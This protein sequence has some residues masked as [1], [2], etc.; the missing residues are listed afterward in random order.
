MLRVT[1]YTASHSITISYS[2]C[3]TCYYVVNMV[4]NPMYKVGIFLLLIQFWDVPKVS[5]TYCPLMRLIIVL[6][7]HH[8]SWWSMGPWL[9]WRANDL[10]YTV[11]ILLPIYGSISVLYFERISQFKFVLLLQ[12]TEY[13]YGKSSLE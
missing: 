13:I 12:V 9:S 1:H 4:M 5:M 10:Q 6:K 3:F 2:E 7:T 8:G 11:S